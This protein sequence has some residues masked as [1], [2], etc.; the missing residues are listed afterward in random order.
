[1]SITQNT[2][3]RLIGAHAFDPSG[4]KIGKIDEIYVDNQTN[5][6]KWASVKTGLF[7][8]DS[9]VPL[10]GAETTDDGVKVAPSKSAVKDAPHLDDK[11]G[12]TGRQEEELFQ[13]Y[14]IAG[15]SGMTG[16]RHSRDG[17]SGVRD[18]DSMIRHEERLDVGKEQEA[19]G[20]AR[21][22]KYV[23]TENEQV[24]V[25]VTRE[26]VVVEREPISTAE[27]RSVPGDT[28]IGEENRDVTLHEERV[29]VNKE[30][31]PVEK[32]RL[33]K[34]QVTDTRTVADDVRKE[35]VETDVDGRDTP[36]C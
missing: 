1:M 23:V 20:Q 7:G 33:G 13:H 25:P 36:K 21:L 6:P 4:D 10:A 32:V 12:I 27:A 14:G 31:V 24:D 30:Q 26:E 11:G 15:Q 17:Q 16:G 22:H 18:D 2:L 35:R 5:E 8:S 29:T 3:D 19:T 9:L 34:E 28:G